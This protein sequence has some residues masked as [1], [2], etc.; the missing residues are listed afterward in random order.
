MS[1]L[2]QCKGK[3]KTGNQCKKM[4]KSGT[5][6]SHHDPKRK[7]I[8]GDENPVCPICY[9]NVTTANKLITRCGHVF[10]ADCINEWLAVKGSCP[11]CRQRLEK[12]KHP[13]NI[14]L[15]LV[16]LVAPPNVPAELVDLWLRNR[17]FALIN[18]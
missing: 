2:H 15:I 4:L 13:S 3:A 1:L 17:R 8:Y 9:C 6:C 12:P 18:R 10:C 14:S 11:V 5:F 16:N 7:C